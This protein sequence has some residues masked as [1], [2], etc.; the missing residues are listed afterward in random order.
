[1]TT[2]AGMRMVVTIIIGTRM[3]RA[4]IITSTAFNIIAIIVGTR[5]T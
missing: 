5:S 3:L 1:M 2:T 4:T